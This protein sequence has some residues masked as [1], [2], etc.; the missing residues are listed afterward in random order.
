LLVEFKEASPRKKLGFIELINEKASDLAQLGSTLLDSYD[1]SGDDW[2]AGWILQVLQ[3]HE[4]ESLKTLLKDN[5]SGWFQCESS[6]GIDY[7]SLQ[8]KLLHENFQEADRLTSSFLRELSGS[9]A[10]ERGYVYFSEAENIPDLDLLTIDRLWIAYSQ[11]RFGFSVQARLLDSLG[12]RYEKLWPRIGWKNDGVWTRYPNSF[13]WTLSA[14]V[15]HMP[16]INQL[17]GVRLFDTVLNHSALKS[18]RN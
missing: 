4:P 15:G 8:Q 6:F 5:S 3:R 7:S 11:G 16:L 1:P 10:V 18:R 17:R 14:P 2:S 12:G 13:N 9:A